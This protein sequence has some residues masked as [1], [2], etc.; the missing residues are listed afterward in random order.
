MML[1]RSATRLSSRRLT[2][3]FLRAKSTQVEVEGHSTSGEGPIGSDGRHEIWREDIYDH[4]NE[5]RWVFFSWNFHVPPFL[6]A[7][8]RQ[9]SSTFST[10]A[11]WW[12]HDETTVL[13]LDSKN[14]CWRTNV[15]YDRLEVSG[16]IKLIRLRVYMFIFSVTIEETWVAMFDASLFDFL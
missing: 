10:W 15:S 8:W 1:L 2:R 12:R 9:H 4:D 7:L 13:F 5:P 16:C 14:C 3:T 11:T 6:P